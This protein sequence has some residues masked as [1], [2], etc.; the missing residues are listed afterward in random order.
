MERSMFID[1]LRVLHVMLWSLQSNE[2]LR[3]MLVASVASYTDKACT[4]AGLRKVEASERIVGMMRCSRRLAAAQ[5]EM[6]QGD[7]EHMSMHE[8]AF[9]DEKEELRRATSM[10]ND[11]IVF[12]RNTGLLFR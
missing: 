8:S 2:D 1:R 6:L 12:C 9:P 5:L 10:L 7:L 4:L 11:M 3:E